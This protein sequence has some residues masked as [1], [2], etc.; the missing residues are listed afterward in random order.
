MRAYQTKLK[1]QAAQLIFRGAIQQPAAIVQLLE[2]CG[3]ILC[4]KNY[5]IGCLSVERESQLDAVD[6]YMRG[7]LHTE[8]VINGRRVIVFLAELPCADPTM[9]LRDRLAA[10]FAD[11]IDT[12]NAGRIQIAMS[13]VYD[14][15]RLAS[16]AYMEATWTMEKME[17]DGG[18][19]QLA[20][21]EHLARKASVTTNLDPANLQA[22]TAALQKKRVTAAIEALDRMEYAIASG[23]D[24]A[25]NQR[26]LRYCILQAVIARLTTDNCP[27]DYVEEAIRF[28]P[29]DPSS[30]STGLHDLI[31]RYCALR[32]RESHFEKAVAYIDAHYNQ[33][34]LSLEEVADYVN[35]SKN[36]LSNLFRTQLGVKYMEYITAL[37]M[38][39]VQTLL[40][41][42]D[43]PIGEVF[44]MAGY[45]DKAN[46]SKKFKSIFRVSAMEVRRAAHEGRLDTLPFRYPSHDP[47]PF[48][49]LHP[50]GP[51]ASEIRPDE[52]DI[53]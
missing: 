30:F 23:C 20:Y 44:R 24:S 21:W 35:L 41:E 29:T 47:T 5:Y 7:D 52:D 45:V 3:L 12:V 4:E 39:K 26:Y 14:D 15:L 36:Y 17:D 1:R 50:I 37:R 9:R 2:F 51:A 33:Y 34:D 42:T 22:L 53:L 46:Y 43:L 32:T 31:T 10:K 48:S 18:H 49:F 40:V 28:D 13:S 11:V 16:Q 25:E 6:E 27:S 8:I 38:S 19:V